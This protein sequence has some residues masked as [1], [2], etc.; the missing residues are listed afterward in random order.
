MKNEA[1]LCFATHFQN[2][3][4]YGW[5]QKEKRKKILY[6]KISAR[7]FLVFLNKTER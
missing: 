7:K 1:S 4:V 3:L 6:T 2:Q 5:E